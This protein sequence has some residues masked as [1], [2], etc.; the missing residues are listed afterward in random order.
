MDNDF[1]FY[2]RLLNAIEQSN[3][4]TNCIE[5]ELGYARNALHNYRNGGRPSGRRLVE[6]AHYFK[7]TPEYLIGKTDDSSPICPE[8]IFDSLD[9]EQKLEMLELSLNWVNSIQKKI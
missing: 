7:L 1:V 6:L 8:I 9:E 3:K 5:K 4:S 2:E